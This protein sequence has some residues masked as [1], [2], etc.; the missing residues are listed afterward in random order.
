MNA[1]SVSRPARCGAHAGGNHSTT[2][3]CRAMPYPQI[4]NASPM[5]DA[6]EYAPFQPF[7]PICAI[8]AVRQSSAKI[9]IECTPRKIN[10]PNIRTDMAG[11]S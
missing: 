4:T 10:N 1:T 7:S 3:A 5:M 2:G 8:R 6:T 11:S 9:R